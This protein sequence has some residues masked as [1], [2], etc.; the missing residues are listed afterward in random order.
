MITESKLNQDLSSKETPT[1]LGTK[2]HDMPFQV[3]AVDDYSKEQIAHSISDKVSVPDSQI[4][5]LFLEL[6]LVQI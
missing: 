3:M 2:E 1:L 5:D 4:E 6:D